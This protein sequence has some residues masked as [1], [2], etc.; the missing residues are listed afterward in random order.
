MDIQKPA[1]N[2][3]KIRKISD[4]PELIHE[5]AGWFHS[6]W[7]VP[8]EEYIKSMEESLNLSS[9]IPQWYVITEEDSIIAG[10]GIIENDF[11]SRKDLSP[12]LCALYVE[13]PFRCQ[14]IAGLLLSFICHDM[15]QK[16]ID[17]LYLVTDHTSFYERYGWQFLCTVQTEEPDAFPVPI[18]M[19][20][21]KTSLQRPLLS[22]ETQI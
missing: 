14:G 8:A 7:G 11:H 5:A 3:R 19:Y 12:N 2:S 20:T 4:C 18:R 22:Q 21:R 17:T 16:G 9:P 1:E 13:E 15:L 10:A 6:K